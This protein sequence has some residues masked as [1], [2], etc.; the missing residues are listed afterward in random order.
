MLRRSGEI[1]ENFN[2]HGFLTLVLLFILSGGLQ[3]QVYYSVNPNYLKAKTEGNNIMRSYR[4]VYPDTSIT[5]F[6]NFFPRN[7]LGNIG[8]PSAPYILKY[9][10]SDLG[11]KVYPVPLENDMFSE[12]QVAYYRTAGP[13]ASL[14]GIVGAKELQIFKMLF[15]HTFKR[16]INVTLRFNR[17]TSTGFYVKQQTYSDNFFLSSNSTSVRKNAGYYLYFLSN[18]NKNAENGGIRNDTLTQQELALNKELIRVNLNGATRSNKELKFMINPWIRL[19]GKDSMNTASHYLQLKSKVGRTIYHYKDTR[20]RQDNFYD[21]VYLD[22]NTTNDS[23]HLKQMSNEVNYILRSKREGMSFSGGYRNEVN[24]LW[25]KADSTFLN[26]LLTGAF[27]Y[28]K[29]FADKDS[30]QKKPVLQNELGFQQVFKGANT[31]DFKIEDRLSFYPDQHSRTVFFADL[32]SESRHPDHIYNHWVGNNFYW[33]DNGYSPQ[34]QLQLRGGFALGRMLEGSVYMQN[35]SNY[36]Y[37]DQNALPRQLS[38]NVQNLGISVNFNKVFFRHLGIG[39]GHTYQGTSHSS[40][41]RLPRNIST[42]RLHY[43]GIH[44][45]NN[46][47]IQF[48]AQLQLYESF[49]AYDYM[50]ATQVFFLQENFKTELYPFVDAYINVRI[51]PVN[52]FLK[53]ENVLQGYAGRNYAFVPG[54]YQP[55]RAFRCGINWM[56]FD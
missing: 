46:L 54:Y 55:D 21:L 50:P 2:C 9:G 33:I 17:Y 56:F 5:D 53:M 1:T 27:T 37:F 16:K 48:G 39:I 11:F 49:Y 36:L 44:F 23:T 29:M 15:T 51:R 8:L 34:Q 22:T 35:I 4:N 12:S 19:A 20:V 18:G 41:V 26:H 30:A 42:T 32:L 14:T 52:I 38:D 45:R 40:Y 24:V 6:H 43:H 25:Q 31:G 3:S 7:F 13:F 10:T 47:Q 28:R